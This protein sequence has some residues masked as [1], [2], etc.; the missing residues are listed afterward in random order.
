MTAKQVQ[1]LLQYLGYYSGPVDGILGS[2]SIAAIR[3]FQAFY[4]LTVDGIAGEHTQKT[5][6][7]AVAGTA[8]QAEK[9]EPSPAEPEEG[10]WWEDIRY[11]KRSEFACKCGRCG[12]FPAEPQEAMVRIADQIR[13][14]FGS[15]AR[16]I[17]GVRCPAHNK[18]VG[19][20]SNSQHMYGEAVDLR[21]D[22]VG[23]SELLAYTKTIPGVRFAYH[24]EGS[25]NIHF[26]IPK[27]DR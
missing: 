1:N 24:I 3:G 19:G 2:R 17:S 11:F 22:G 14:H 23:W 5:L 20:K 8:V 6:I 27:G 21:V 16:V 13:G 4:G 25:N 18:A 9:T 15:P 7:D 10:D 12:G 26:D